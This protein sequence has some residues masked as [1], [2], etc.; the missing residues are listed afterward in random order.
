MAASNRLGPGIGEERIK[1]VLDIYPNILTDYSKWT[2]EDFIKRLENINGL[3]EKTATLFVNNF[4]DF[5]IFYNSIKKYV[6]VELK[7]NQIVTGNLTGKTIVL[8]GFRDQAL[9]EKI[10][11]CGGRIGTSIS[12][13]TD[14]LI[15]RDQTFIDNP[16]SKITKALSI[17]VKIITRKKLETMRRSRS[18]SPASSPSRLRLHRRRRHHR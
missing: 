12:K 3:K 6:T 9:Q 1:Q 8:T 2:K 7:P 13:N 16:T 18:R 5:I 15:V 4:N 10:I 17:G 14:Y 11:A